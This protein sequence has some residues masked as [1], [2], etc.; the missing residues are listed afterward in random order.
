[1]SLEGRDLTK[2]IR[3]EGG[4]W[5][6]YSEA[7]KPMGTYDTEAGAKHRLQQIEYFKH[8]K[9][10]METLRELHSILVSGRSRPRVTFPGNTSTSSFGSGG[11]MEHTGGSYKT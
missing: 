9:K 5:T 8:V 11:G 1:M 10:G 2:Y 7:G 3:R 6:V 4:K